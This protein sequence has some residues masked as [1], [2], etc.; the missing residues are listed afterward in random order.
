MDRLK[1]INALRSKIDQLDNEL[2][3]LLRERLRVA[4]EI[5][6]IKK[7]NNIPVVDP[8]RESDLSDRLGKLTDNDFL[9]KDFVNRLWKLILVES[10]RVQLEEMD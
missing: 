9:T 7:D 5:G 4:R 8:E 1:E 6:Q 2:I 10:Y 3:Q